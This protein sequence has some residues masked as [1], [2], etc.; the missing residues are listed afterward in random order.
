MEGV[1]RCLNQASPFFIMKYKYLKQLV[2]EIDMK[3]DNMRT[4]KIVGGTAFIH[5]ITVYE[6]WKVITIN[7]VGTILSNFTFKDE[8][9]ATEKYENIMETN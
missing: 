1:G 7:G 3:L 5:K 8:E 9:L 4:K 6:I 2:L